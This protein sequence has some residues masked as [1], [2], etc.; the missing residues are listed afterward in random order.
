VSRF[1]DW[2]IAA[3][4]LLL[5]RRRKARLRRAEDRVVA[6]GLPRPGSELLAVAA[7]GAASLCAVAFVVVY[8]VD[9]LPAHTQLL[10]LSIGLCFAFVT[11][12]FLVVALRVAPEEEPEGEYHETAPDEQLAVERIV[13]ES[14]DS[15][16]RKR[17]LKLAAGGAAGTIGVALV[18]PVLSLGP[19]LHTAPFYR[20]PWRRGRRLVDER[21]RPYRARDIEEETF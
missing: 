10:G 9:S 3:V 19:F 6:G 11:A 4:V 17:L 14:G 12:A 1:V 15:F 2:L 7:L 5:G 8:A 21:G 13:D 18:T 16:T 20:T